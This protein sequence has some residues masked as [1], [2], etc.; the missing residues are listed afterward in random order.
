MY[1]FVMFFGLLAILCA[2]HVNAEVTVAA[3]FRDHMVLQRDMKVPVWGWGEPGEPVVVEFMNVVNK[4]QVDASGRWQVSLG[5]FPA[6]G[7]YEMKITGKTA[8]VIKNILMGEVWICT[9]QS[10]IQWPVSEMEG[11]DRELANANYPEIR[12]VSVWGSASLQPQKDLKSDWPSCHWGQSNSTTA[13]IFSAPGFFFARD[14][15]RVLKV[16]V[17]I[18]ATAEGSS[19]IRAWISPTVQQSNPLFKPILEDYAT[20]AERKKP[21]T[22]YLAAMKKAKAEGTKEPP[23]PGFFEAYGDGPGMFYNS[24]VSPLAPFAIRGMIWWQGENEAIYKHGQMYKDLLPVMIHDWRTLWRQGDFPFI[25]IQLQSFGAP[26]KTPVDSEWA[27]V[28]D[29]QRQT[30]QVTNTALVITTDIC[31]AALHPRKKVELGSR[32]AQAA[33]AIAYGEKLVYS[34]PLFDAVTFKDGQAILT[35]AQVGG[36]LLVKGDTLYGFTI[37]GSDKKYVSAKA[38]IKGATVVVSSEAVSDPK[39]VRYA[40]ADNPSGNLFNKE[41]LPASCFRMEDW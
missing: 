19:P 10:N 3:I 16:P 9:G 33:R 37:A 8:R 15:Y 2:T 41:G 32:L 4:A 1:K 30:L 38:E 25:I 31:E 20:Y 28:R 13:R 36:G 11:A 24:R 18:I 26:S 14:L 22:S 27:E 7:P 39:G 23:F 12:L 21:Y 6:G 34:G 17:G 35:F 29:G 5:P 40:W